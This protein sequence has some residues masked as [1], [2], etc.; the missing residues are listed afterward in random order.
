MPATNELSL[1]EET[2]L[3]DQCTVFLAGH[4]SLTAA[5]LLSTIPADT[6]PDR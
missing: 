4:G 2:A 5:D 1:A 3:R 6:V